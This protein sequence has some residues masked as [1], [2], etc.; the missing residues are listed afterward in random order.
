[1]RINDVMRIQEGFKQYQQKSQGKNIGKEITEKFE[2]NVIEA[3]MGRIKKKNKGEMLPI[4]TQANPAY[5]LSLSSPKTP[6]W[7]KFYTK[8]EATMSDEEIENAVKTLALEFAEKSMEIGN[9]GKG[10]AMI[11]SMLDKL[12]SEYNN[13]MVDLDLMYVSVVSP[14]RKAAYA[15]TDFTKGNAV[16]GNEPTMYG[17]MGNELLEWGPSGWSTICTAAEHERSKRLTN[18][19]VDTIRA[20]EAENGQIPYTT[21]SRAVAPPKNWV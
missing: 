8:R 18:I 19:Y 7:D 14:D 1:M 16:Y 21:I 12:R 11:N 15:K 6:M 9:S 20:Y 2:F 4:N 13:K 5:N 10:K 3:L 17:P